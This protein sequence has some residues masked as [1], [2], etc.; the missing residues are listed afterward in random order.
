MSA[1]NDIPVDTAIREVVTLAATTGSGT[2]SNPDL[3]SAKAT[4][5]YIA[6]IREVDGNISV[7]VRFGSQDDLAL[8]GLVPVRALNDLLVKI[9]NGK[10]GPN[11]EFY[12]RLS[13]GSNGAARLVAFG[14]AGGASEN[15]IHLLQVRDGK[16]SNIELVGALLEEFHLVLRIALL[17]AGADQTMASKLGPEEVVGVPV[18]AVSHEQIDVTTTDS[19]APQIKPPHNVDDLLSTPMDF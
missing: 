16:Q 3:E 10:S 17:R 11:F 15:V 1:N 12:K 5:S 19:T 7:L 13:N 18:K 6:R 2:E 4:N 9:V 14:E 8:E